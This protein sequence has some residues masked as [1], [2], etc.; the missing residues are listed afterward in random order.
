MTRLNDTDRR[1]FLRR[2]ALGAGALWTLSLDAFMAR[3]ASASPAI[4]SPYGPI[5]P[6][7]DQATG[8]PLLQLPDGFR[9]WSY[10]WTGDLMSDGV[11]T[12]SLHDGMA[13][14]DEIGRDDWH[15]H[16]DD[17]RNRVGLPAGSR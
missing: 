12:P 9:Y 5:G 10:G 13:V 17:R 2:G 8:L 7:R 14:I 4:P 3:R 1:T 16:D 6:E 11:V 15:E